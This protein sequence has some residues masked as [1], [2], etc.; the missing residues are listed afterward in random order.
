MSNRYQINLAF[1]NGETVYLLTDIQQQKRIVTGASIRGKYPNQLITYCLVLD[2][3][4]SWHADYE[5]SRKRNVAIA[6]GI[7]NDRPLVDN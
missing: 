2:S 1:A 4:E 5:I 7:D 3:F 6:T